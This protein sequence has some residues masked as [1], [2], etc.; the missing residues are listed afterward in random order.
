MIVGQFNSVVAQEKINGENLSKEIPSKRSGTSELEV[1][2]PYA[3]LYVVSDK[4]LPLFFLSGEIPAD[5]PKYD[6]NLSK[7]KNVK[8][9][10]K[11]LNE[12]TNYSLLTDEGKKKVD[13]KTKKMQ[14]QI[15][16]K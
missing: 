13:E 6:S 15:S 10:L 11:W 14:E 3:P 1:R 9:A 2:K 16:R 12:P 7:N 4:K 8:I 5:F